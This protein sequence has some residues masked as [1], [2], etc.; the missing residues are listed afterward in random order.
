VVLAAHIGDGTSRT[1]EYSSRPLVAVGYVPQDV[2][3]LRRS[4][5]RTSSQ[6]KED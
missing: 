5:R 6:L 1:A 2:L 3:C 4:T